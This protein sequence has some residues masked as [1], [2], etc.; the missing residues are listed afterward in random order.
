[1][2]QLF[3][4]RIFILA[5]IL[6]GCSVAAQEPPPPLTH[7]QPLCGKRAEFVSQ[8]KTRYAEK[9]VSVGLASNGVMIE[10]FASRTGSFTILV[11]R[12]EGVSCMV[13]SG[14]N[15]QDLPTQKATGED[16]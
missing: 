10:V 8:L 5:M 13:T 4:F 9:P 14:D 1:M 7:A 15:W 3:S 2:I 12:P 11:T 16:T 6:S